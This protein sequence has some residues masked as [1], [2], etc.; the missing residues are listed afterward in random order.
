MPS[1]KTAVENKTSVPL[2]DPTCPEREVIKE[3]K[4][5][6]A[7][8][9]IL[10]MY[11]AALKGDTEEN[12]EKFYSCFAKTQK[13]TFVKDEHWP[14][15]IKFV[16]KYI[17]NPDQPAYTICKKVPSGEESIKIYIQSND[18]QKT[19]PPI[20]LLKEDGALK[21]EVFTP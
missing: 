5:G 13:K 7:E 21:V 9:V 3:P 8:N 10:Q 2:G 14:R 4:E 18:P 20:L 16:R 1:D 19:N 6:T 12:F 17:Q 15:I 11:L